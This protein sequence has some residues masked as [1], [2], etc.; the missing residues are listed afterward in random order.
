M[1]V[2]VP[3][4]GCSI[5]L[6]PQSKIITG[7]CVISHCPCGKIIS[8]SD[9][10]GKYSGGCIIVVSVV[11]QFSIKHNGTICCGPVTRKSYTEGRSVWCKYTTIRPYR[12][13]ICPVGVLYCLYA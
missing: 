3:Q 10:G 12:Q 1:S 4:F 8:S 13:R 2:C 6:K 11:T 9:R 7:V 5:F